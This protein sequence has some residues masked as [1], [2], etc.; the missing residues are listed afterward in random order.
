MSCLTWLVRNRCPAVIAT[1]PPLQIVHQKWLR[2]V[3][4]LDLLLIAVTLV[5][6][7]N[8]YSLNLQIATN[9]EVFN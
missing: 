6:K 7:A 3:E 5:Q 2:Q 9:C 4:I 1:T 8:V